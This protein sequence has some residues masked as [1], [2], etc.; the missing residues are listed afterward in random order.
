TSDELTLPEKIIE[1]VKITVK[2]ITGLLDSIIDLWLNMAIPLA[3]RGAKILGLNPDTA[4]LP[5][6]LKKLD[7]IWE[8]EEL[9]FSER[10]IESIKITVMSV[11]GLIDSILSW[12]L[13]QTIELARKTVKFLGLDPD[14]NALVQF[15]ERIKKWW[16]EHDVTLDEK[17]VDAAI[18]W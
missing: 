10:V 12:W 8:N 4:W 5:S 7:E 14:E 13:G 2:T 6:F 17:K 1:T 16:D 18:D 9:S 11:S 3:E 15:L